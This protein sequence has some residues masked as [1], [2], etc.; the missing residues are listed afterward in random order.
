MKVILLLSAAYA[1]GGAYVDAGASL[2]IGD[3]KSEITA[4]RAKDMEKSKLGTI[5]EVAD[6]GDDD[7]KQPPRGGR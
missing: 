2:P 5:S 7:G 3:G 1:N 4:D 6:E